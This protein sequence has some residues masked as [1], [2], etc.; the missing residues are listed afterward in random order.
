MPTVTLGNTAPIETRKP[1]DS[2]LEFERVPRE[3]IGETYTVFSVPEG[4]SLIESVTTIT[5]AFDGHHS[6]DA[7]AWVESDDP[8][9]A[10]A[11]AQHYKCE[12]R[13]SDEG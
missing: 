4:T 5:R 9:L 2:V 7:A 6:D 1:D 10:E 13:K 12:I 8:I 3:D 11:L